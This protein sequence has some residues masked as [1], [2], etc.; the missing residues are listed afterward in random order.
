[1][2]RRVTICAVSLFFF[3][4]SMLLAREVGL[5]MSSRQVITATRT[6][7]PASTLTEAATEVH[8]FRTNVPSGMVSSTGMTSM[9]HNIIVEGMSNTVEEILAAGG[10]LRFSTTGF[11]QFAAGQ[12]VSV[13]NAGILVSSVHTIGVAE[14]D[15]V[16]V[17]KVDFSD[18]V[19]TSAVITLIGT[20]DD[21]VADTLGIDAG[22]VTMDELNAGT[23]SVMRTETPLISGGGTNAAVTRMYHNLF[24]QEATSTSYAEVSS[25]TSV[26][27]PAVYAPDVYTGDVRTVLSE[28]LVPYTNVIPVTYENWTTNYYTPTV[29]TNSAGAMTNV[30]WD[31]VVTNQPSGT[32]LTNT[33]PYGQ[34]GTGEDAVFNPTN[35]L[36]TLDNGSVATNYPYWV[37]YEFVVAT[38]VTNVVDIPFYEYTNSTTVFTNETPYRIPDT[39]YVGVCSTSYV[40]IGFSPGILHTNSSGRCYILEPE[41]IQPA[42]SGTEGDPYIITV[43]ENFRWVREEHKPGGM[44]GEYQ[45][46]YYSE[47]GGGPMSAY[48]SPAAWPTSREITNGVMDAMVT[49]CVQTN[50]LDMLETYL[51]CYRQ[52]P[53]GGHVSGFIGISGAPATRY[54]LSATNTVPASTTNLVVQPWYL[55][56]YVESHLAVTQWPNRRFVHHLN[57]DGRGHSMLGVWGEI[58]PHTIIGARGLLGCAVVSPTVKN[59]TIG[60]YLGGEWP[61]IHNIQMEGSVN[62]GAGAISC[63]GLFGTANLAV[64]RHYSTGRADHWPSDDPGRY[65]LLTQAVDTAYGTLISNCTVFADIDVDVTGTLRTTSTSSA[66]VPFVNIGG[67]FGSGRTITGSGY[68]ANKL[69]IST[70]VAL[71]G[72]NRPVHILNSSFVGRHSATTENQGSWLRCNRIVGRMIGGISGDNSTYGSGIAYFL[73]D[74]VHMARNIYLSNTSIDGGAPVY[75]AW[76][77]RPILTC[78]DGMDAVGNSTVGLYGSSAGL[79]GTTWAELGLPTNTIATTW[80]RVSEIGYYGNVSVRKWYA[81]AD[82]NDSRHVSILVGLAGRYGRIYPST[83]YSIGNTP[84]RL[85]NTGDYAYRAVVA[86]DAVQV[87]SPDPEGSWMVCSPDGSGDNQDYTGVYDSESILT[88][89]AAGLRDETYASAYYRARDAWPDDRFT[90]PG[91]RI[92]GEG[93]MKETYV[94]EPDNEINGGGVT[95]DPAY[96]YSGYDDTK[97]TRPGEL[98]GW[99][100]VPIGAAGLS[101]QESGSVVTSSYAVVTNDLGGGIESVTGGFDV[102]TSEIRDGSLMFTNRYAVDAEYINSLTCRLEVVSQLYYRQSTLSSVQTS[103]VDVVVTNRVSTYTGMVTVAGTFIGTG[104]MTPSGDVYRTQGDYIEA[105]P[106]SYS[107]GQEP[108]EYGMF[109]ITGSNLTSVTVSSFLTV[110]PSNYISFADA[111]NSVHVEW[112]PDDISTSGLSAWLMHT[113]TLTELDSKYLYCEPDAGD[114]V[115]LAAPV[116]ISGYLIVR[117]GHPTNNLVYASSDVM[118]YP[119]V[120]SVLTN[121]NFVAIAQVAFTPPP[122]ASPLMTPVP[123]S[124]WTTNYCGAATNAG[125]VTTSAAYIDGTNAPY[126]AGLRVDLYN[127][128]GAALSDNAFFDSVQAYCNYSKP[129]YLIPG[130]P[131]Y[132]VRT[133][134][135][136]T[137]GYLLYDIYARQ[138]V[139]FHV[140]GSLGSS[141]TITLIQGE[142]P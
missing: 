73:G 41:G 38:P 83:G 5:R 77:G 114:S 21:T 104:N 118:Y 47:D 130:G 91:L 94:V 37:D 127:V 106:G 48:G 16:W 125:A 58:N 134:V 56:Y 46:T 72:A 28:T 7:I 117:P 133:R 68:E 1:M 20:V 107:P 13:Y 112:W 76:V 132:P 9:V 110:T 64:S 120:G 62:S 25:A 109:R 89:N 93:A 43:P 138:L 69:G 82:I 36:F 86:Y 108:N 2:I 85:L 35:A 84:S 66:Y 137:E 10:A 33:I 65:A 135:S 29:Y 113:G 97:W 45:S 136:D 15:E 53:N 18:T 81:S 131:H 63:G 8:R 75:P 105:W 17:G 88:I 99:Y 30:T 50:D 140:T 6:M 95:H 122:V 14:A 71:S 3:I 74:G 128:D 79:Y 60:G 124:F 111:V 24:R 22:S 12:T 126:A 44:M 70:L 61:A 26:V 55:P 121:T 27:P 87:S 57:Y 11:Y 101:F 31:A 92:S 98:D 59:L 103:R 32:V 123:A 67:V 119:D 100:P 49:Y 34:T 96:P 129:E 141:V 39:G 51:W 78:I 4:M 40:D 139:T 115:G 102:V 90:E 80:P 42:G 142:W 54:G 116:D 23:V 19:S 52:F